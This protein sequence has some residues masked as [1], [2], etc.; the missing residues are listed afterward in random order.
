MLMSHRLYDKEVIELSSEVL[1]ILVCPPCEEMCTPPN[2]PDGFTHLTDYSPLPF[3]AFEMSNMMTYQPSIMS[4]YCRLSSILELENYCMQQVVRQ[5]ICH[6]QLNHLKERQSTLAG[7]QQSV[8]ELWRSSRWVFDTIQTCQDKNLDSGVRV[9]SLYRTG[10]SGGW[11]ELN[12]VGGL[13]VGDTTRCSISSTGT[14]AHSR[15]SDFSDDPNSSLNS[16]RS[17]SCASSKSASSCSSKV[18]HVVVVHGS[19]E[20]GLHPTKSVQVQTTER[21]RTCDIIQMAARLLEDGGRCEGGC[22]VAFSAE[23]MERLCLVVVV[24]GGSGE[25]ICICDD[26]LAD[27]V[28]DRGTTYL[29]WK[30]GMT[31]KQPQ[32]QQPQQQQQQQQ[33]LQQ[34]QQQQQQQQ[35]ILDVGTTV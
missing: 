28:W 3:Q 8:D 13:G 1:F 4:A 35:P 24:D 5:T 33:Q 7:F 12:G 30:K 10:G 21:T 22:S 23:E 16:I 14:T 6:K 29:R 27:A 19:T 20:V 18:D 26:N 15:S 17:V 25:E 34:Q 11:G 31:Q 32:S 9:A 2:Q